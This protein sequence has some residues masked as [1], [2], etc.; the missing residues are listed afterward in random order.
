MREARGDPKQQ[1]RT[2][3]MKIQ[4]VKVEVFT[5]GNGP[6]RD[7]FAFDNAHPAAKQYGINHAAHIIAKQRGAMSCDRV[8]VIA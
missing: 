6:I 7:K 4:I 2:D 1:Q 3:T 5:N 8:T